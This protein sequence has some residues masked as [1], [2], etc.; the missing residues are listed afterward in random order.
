MTTAGK[1]LRIALGDPGA[2]SGTVDGGIDGVV[3]R[4]FGIVG[5]RSVDPR[6]FTTHGRDHHVANAEMRAAVVGVDPPTAFLGAGG[7]R[8]DQGDAENE[9]KSAH[10]YVCKKH[11]LRMTSQLRLALISFIAPEL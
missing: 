4:I 10:I 8:K 2:Q 3:S 5:H 11:L 1:Y 9:E 7:E 6:E